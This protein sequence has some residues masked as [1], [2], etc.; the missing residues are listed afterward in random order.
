[1]VCTDWLAFAGTEIVNTSRARVYAAAYGIDVECEPCPG[2]DEALKV[3]DPNWYG[4][5]ASPAE[6]DAP[7]YDPAV[8]ESARFLGVIGLSF[9]GFSTNPIE[10]TLTPRIGDGSFIGNLR[11]TAREINLS[12]ALVAAD[13]QAMVWGLEWL[14]A[15]LR[16]SAC[17][18]DACGGDDLC[19]FA[20][21]PCPPDGPT[22]EWGDREMRHLYDVGLVEGP[23]END[24][25]DMPG[26]KCGDT[27]D[28]GPPMI[29]QVSVT[30]TAGLP[31]LYH[32]PI[33][34]VPGSPEWAYITQG[35][36]VTGYDPDQDDCPPVPDCLADPA[37]PLLP[38]LPEVPVPRDPCYP[39]G[40]YNA[41][42]TRF[43]YE[44]VRASEWRELVPVLVVETGGAPLR[45]LSLR[46][47][48]NPNGLDCSDL[49]NCSSCGHLTVAYL[50]AN[51][52]FQVDGR[53]SRAAVDCPSAN[54]SAF[55]LPNLFGQ[56]GG[57]YSWPVMECGGAACVEVYAAT[58][59]D[60]EA[61]VRMEL[62]PRG[63]LA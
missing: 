25:F 13:E 8:P 39:S 22:Q 11:R 41:W 63:D 1:M 48:P 44:P 29:S 21:C 37:C 32:E 50:P 60:A 57:A 14:A 30:L 26:L 56:R 18:P 54:G 55:S 52:T 31:W 47:I 27:S 5:Y 2:L 10:R 17:G 49:S 34:P 35:E 4:G 59:A 24:R 45:R 15:V 38:Q 20:A 16:G 23:A 58:D 6:D 62:V 3:S 7:W 51:A 43:S 36:L 33:P 9:L 61:R 53:V 40:P 46:I 42:R 28:C 19:V 12:L